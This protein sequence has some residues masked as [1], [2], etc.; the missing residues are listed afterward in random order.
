I[1]G[2][3]KIDFVFLIGGGGMSPPPLRIGD[4]VLILNRRHAFLRLKFVPALNLKNF[5]VFVQTLRVRS[6]TISNIGRVSYP[7]PKSVD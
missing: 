5:Q 3:K 2:F 6:K 4:K 7:A 1:D